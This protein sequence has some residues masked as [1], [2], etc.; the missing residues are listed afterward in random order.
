MDLGEYK[1]ANGAGREVTGPHV[2]PDVKYSISYKLVL[3]HPKKK[4]VFHLTK[5]LDPNSVGEA[6]GS[7]PQNPDCRTLRWAN[8]LVSL[9]KK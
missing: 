1:P 4:P 5:L 7:K 2:P 9:L 3:P 6:Q 8:G